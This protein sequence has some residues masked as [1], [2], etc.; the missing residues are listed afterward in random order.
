MFRARWMGK[1]WLC[2]KSSSLFL[3]LPMIERNL[4]SALEVYV[5]SQP[6]QPFILGYFC[7]CEGCLCGGLTDLQIMGARILQTMAWKDVNSLDYYSACASLGDQ[8]YSVSTLLHNASYPCS[9]VNCYS[10]SCLSV[11]S[12]FTIIGIL[13]CFRVSFSIMRVIKKRVIKNHL[14]SGH[15]IHQ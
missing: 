12:S 15:R 14:S 10:Y 5:T 8:I 7:W 1:I 13:W 4:L 3:L 6:F 2:E 11:I 9:P